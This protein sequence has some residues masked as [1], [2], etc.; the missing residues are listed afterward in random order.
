[1]LAQ[2]T[3]LDVV[4]YGFMEKPQVDLIV[5]GNIAVQKED[6][7]RVHTSFTKIGG[8]GWYCGVG[9]SL[10]AKPDTVGV[11][12][13][14]GADHKEL[15]D[16][17]R[18]IGIHTEG[19][20]VDYDHK[21]AQFHVVER[22]ANRNFS[23]QL[24]AAEHMNP[25][26]FPLT[27]RNAT[28]IHLATNAPQIQ[29]EW[30]L[31]LRKVCRPDASISVDIFESYIQE[32]VEE[33]RWIIEHAD[34]LF[35][36]EAERSILSQESISIPIPYILKQGKKGASYH[37]KSKKIEI[38]AQNVIVVSTSGAGDVLASVFLVKR[39]QGED[40]QK[41]LQEAVDAASMSV[42]G[43]GVEHLL[44]TRSS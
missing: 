1:M 9:A 40:I 8:A 7:K 24:N 22:E 41:S 23:A 21:T 31:Y 43:S 32:H 16:I 20:I 38:P 36:N 12:S 13:T 30:I 2:N 18:S 17:L 14:I 33:T 42:Q 26:Q 35:L 44:T 28:H 10:V 25:H 39:M 19:I 3:S 11:V 5:V 34:L 4:Y 6:N 15:V 27:Y 29:K 37:D